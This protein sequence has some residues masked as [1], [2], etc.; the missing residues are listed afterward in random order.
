MTRI[1][2]GVKE[3]T[4]VKRENREIL[5]W[6]W[7]ISQQAVRAKTQKTAKNGERRRKT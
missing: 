2:I 4:W 1:R 6:I 7:I 5:V 3:I